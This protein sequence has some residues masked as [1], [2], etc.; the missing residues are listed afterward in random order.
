LHKATEVIIL[1][2]RI[3]RVAFND[4]GKFVASGTVL[5]LAG[6]GVIAN[7]VTIIVVYRTPGL[8]YE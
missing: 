5:P 2:L 7:I 3:F 4:V 8:R 1:N 6:F